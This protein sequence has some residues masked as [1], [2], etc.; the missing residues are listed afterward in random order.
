M[1]T[2][3]RYADSMDRRMND[4]ILDRIARDGPLATLSTIELALDKEPVTVDPNPEKAKA[5][6]RFGP[7]PVRVDA[8]VCRWT[9]HAVG[10]RFQAAGKEHRCWVWRG[11]VEQIVDPQRGTTA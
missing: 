10:I 8:E 11:A 6:V 1:G 5:W 3:R 2:N 4:R 9:L 7:T